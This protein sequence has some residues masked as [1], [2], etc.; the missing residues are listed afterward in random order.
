[1]TR[2]PTDLPR[3]QAVAAIGQS[4]LVEAYERAFRPMVTTPHR[5]C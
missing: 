2:R 1:M 3:L 4:L 5:Y